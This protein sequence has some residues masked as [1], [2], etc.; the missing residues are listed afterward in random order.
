MKLGLKSALG[1][2]VAHLALVGVLAIGLE[3]TLRSLEEEIGADTV[4]LLAREQAN[5][6]FERSAAAL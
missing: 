1:L 2:V 5:L 3:R 4:R 6:V